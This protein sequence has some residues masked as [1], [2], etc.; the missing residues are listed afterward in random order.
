MF[1]V[2]HDDVAQAWAPLGNGYG[3]GF[4]GYGRR[5]E[6][7]PSIGGWGLEPQ[8]GSLLYE[9][10]DAYKAAYGD[11]MPAAALAGVS[12]DRGGSL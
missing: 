12:G 5:Q 1:A 3:Q 7:L 4:Y 10:D 9:A 8:A 11:E 6:S 2:T